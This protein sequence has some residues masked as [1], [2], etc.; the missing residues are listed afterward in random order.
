MGRWAKRPASWNV[1]LAPKA[2]ATGSR[3]R[4]VDPLSPQSNR[5]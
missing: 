5:Q 2:P 3:K 4:R 1:A